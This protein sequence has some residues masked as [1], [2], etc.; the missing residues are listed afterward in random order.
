VVIV[1]RALRAALRNA[2][3]P[4]R[5]WGRILRAPFVPGRLDVV[6]VRGLP[7]AAGPD[8][9]LDVYHCRDR[10]AG[11]PVLPHFHGGGFYSGTKSRE[12]R[13]LIRYLTSTSSRTPPISQSAQPQ[14]PL[15]PVRAARKRPPVLSLQGRHQPGHILRGPRSWL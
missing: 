7:Y 3:N 14:Q 10:P 9:T 6:R 1:R 11:A 4:G 5:P 13:P 2:G 15:H 12:A 8:R